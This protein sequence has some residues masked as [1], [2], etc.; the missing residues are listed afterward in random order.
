MPLRY[1]SKILML[2]LIS[3]M[4]FCVQCGKKPGH[5]KTP[6]LMKKKL[7][8]NGEQAEQVKNII[9][10]IKDLR[11]KERS[12]Y[13]GDNESLL[14]A[15]RARKA[16][17]Y[18]RIESILNESQKTRFERFMA[19]KEVTDR[20]LIISERLG[21]D[22]TTTKRI[23]KIV[24]KAPTDEEVIVAK[25]SGDPAK[26]EAVKAKSDKIN[27]EI[28][29]FLNDEQK[30]AF[31]D[32][33]REEAARID[34]MAQREIRTQKKVSDRALLMG[35]RLGLDY[36]T[37]TK[38]DR[39]VAN[40]PTDEEI[41]AVKESACPVKLKA[42]KEKADGI[43]RE[44]ESLLD[45]VQKVAFTKMIQEKCKINSIVAKPCGF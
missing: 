22:R 25:Q 8:L 38:L 31:Q 34:K 42:L 2:V 27:K 32:L 7:G 26:F 39:I 45:D 15:A 6:Y 18:K 20:T 21:L 16:L 23:D 9:N 37:I 40:A 12:Q 10:E 35:E 24:V 4:A 17:E 44:I 11:E 13:E 36:D 30:I 43:H 5:D 28:E 14:K 1:R 41:M 3:L 19:E 33:I 29:Y